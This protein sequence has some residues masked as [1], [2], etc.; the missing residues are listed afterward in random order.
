MAV[1][2]GEGRCKNAKKL[3]LPT[4]AVVDQ[5]KK[6]GCSPCICRRSPLS[7]CR[8]VCTVRRPC[9]VRV[10]FRRGSS[11]VCKKVSVPLR[12]CQLPPAF[13]CRV[14][15]FVLLF[16]L[17]SS[18]PSSSSLIIWCLSVKF[19]SIVCRCAALRLWFGST[20]L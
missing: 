2:Y 12:L 19:D 14:G 8:G 5:S 11:F 17:S 10:C 7:V 3:V 4:G 20:A 1:V 15:S 6:R 16:A 18:P 9:R 13:A